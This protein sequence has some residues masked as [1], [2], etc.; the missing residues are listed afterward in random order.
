MSALNRNSSLARGLVGAWVDFR[1]T[2]LASTRLV[3]NY[4]RPDLP[5]QVGDGTPGAGVGS[6]GSHASYANNPISGG[7]VVFPAGTTWDGNQTSVF[8]VTRRTGSGSAGYYRIATMWDSAALGTRYWFSFFFWGP[9]STL[10][11][12]TTPIGIGT[13]AELFASAARPNVGDWFTVSAT[14]HAR[15]TTPYA[16]VAPSLFLNGKSLPVSVVNSPITVNTTGAPYLTVGSMAA[17]GLGVA[18]PTDVAAVYLWIR[19]LQPDEHR[20]LHENPYAPLSPLY[21]E[22]LAWESNPSTSPIWLHNLLHRRRG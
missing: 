6:Y 18:D 10:R 7:K 8:A 21:Q 5:L 11:C 13:N 16:S 1:G 17:D 20:Q 4:A 19:G 22:G 14:G 2:A 15:H 9:T 3:R 12:V